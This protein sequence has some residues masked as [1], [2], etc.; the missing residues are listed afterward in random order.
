MTSL[1]ALTTASRVTVFRHAESIYADELLVIRARTDRVFAVLLVL[2]WLAGIVT[3]VWVSPFSWAGAGNSIHPHLL[4][5]VFLGGSFTLFPLMLV[6][7]Q[8][9]AAVTRHVVAASQIM[10]SGLFIHLTAGRIETHFHIFGSLA[11]LAWYMD[12]RVL[13]TATALVIADH[14]ARGFYWPESVFGT[15][16]PGVWRTF[17]HT[18]WILFEDTFLVIWISFG[19]RTLWGNALQ[20]SRLQQTN[21]LIESRVRDRTGQLQ[22]YAEEMETA[23]HQ[24]EKQARE[25]ASQAENLKRANQEAEQANRAK[26]EFL[27]NMSHEIRTPMTAILGFTDILQGSLDR[28]EQL[29][30]AQ[31]IKRNGAYLL[32]LVNDILDLSK[33]EAG[34]VQVERIRCHTLALV[35]EVA[36][37]MRVRAAAKGLPLDVEY[38]G[39]IPETIETD[40]TRLR[41]IL[42]NLIGNAIKFTEVGRVRLVVQ[43]RQRQTGPRLR[44]D[45]IDTGLGM[46]PEQVA[47][48]FRPFTQADASTTRRFG[49]TG[50]GLTISKRFAEMLDGDLSVRSSLGAGSTFTVEVAT[51]SLAE[52]KMLTGPFEASTIPVHRTPQV[53]IRISG[54]VLL[55]EDGPDNQRLISFVLERAGAT[56]TLADNGQV[57]V[58]LALASLRDGRPFDCLLMDMQMPIM[59]GYEATRRMRAAGYRA[60]IIALTAHAMAGDEKKCLAAGCDAYTTKPI[61]RQ[62]LL[63]LVARYCPPQTPLAA[64]QNSAAAD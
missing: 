60:P 1:S 42:I 57:A 47:R 28:P 40:P 18:T 6:A 62:G 10:W 5:A 48:L 52:V 35:A 26:S 20:Q 34:K 44:I 45:V 49:G 12:P 27:A 37:L 25:L 4:A 53:D 22:A 2:Q 24:L 46:T 39:P 51:G 21:M 41:Q 58:E 50:L 13:A 15:S 64:A 55:A 56:V 19:L 31:T 43:V 14:L 59:D 30:A 16:T 23:Q 8:P 3:A 17:E 33:I 63:E 11:F 38:S 32:E 36:S 29:D 61:Q 7:L 9:G 54:H